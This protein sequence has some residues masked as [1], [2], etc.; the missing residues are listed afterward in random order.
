MRHPDRRAGRIDFEP[1]K[2]APPPPRRDHRDGPGAL[3]AVGAREQREAFIGSG[4]RVIPLRR[5]AQRRQ[6]VCRTLL[7]PP[8]QT[9]LLLRQKT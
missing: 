5:V 6:R 3:G 1:R 2:G 8:G 9:L 7:R 4:A